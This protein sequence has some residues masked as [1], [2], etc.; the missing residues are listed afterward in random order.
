MRTKEERLR[1]L[2]ERI[3][4][5][6]DTGEAQVRRLVIDRMCRVLRLAGL[7]NEEIA[8]WLPLIRKLVR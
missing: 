5:R 2:L 8:D 4:T 3:A 6:Y 1:F 7:S